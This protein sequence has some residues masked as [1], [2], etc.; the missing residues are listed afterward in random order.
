MRTLF[1]VKIRSLINSIRRSSGRKYPALILF[2]TALLIILG[3]FSV[4]IFGFIYTQKEF[5]EPLRF[6]LSKQL[7]TM[8]F[9]T[10]F[11]MLILSA[12]ISTLNIFFL[13]K[14]LKLLFSSPI[15]ENKIFFWK[16]I[17]VAINS[18]IMVVFFSAPVLFGFLYYF[19]PGILTISMTLISFLLFIL[20]GVGIGI[21]TGFIIPAFISVKRLQPVLSVISILFISLAIIFFRMLQPEKFGNPEILDNVLKFIKGFS[22]PIFNF[23]PFQWLSESMISVSKGDLPRY[24]RLTSYFSLL[25]L[26][27]FIFLRI[28]GKK[29]YFSLYDKINRGSRGSKRSVWNRKS[30]KGDFGTLLKKESRTF[31]RTPEH[32]SQ[33]LVIGAIA[34]IFIINMKAIPAPSAAVKNIIAY[35]NIGMAA[36]IVAGLNSRFTFTSIPMENPGVVY[37]LSSP[38]KREKVLKFKLIVNLIP[39][40]FIS[41]SLFFT[42]EITLKLDIV[43]RV[44]GTLYLIP[45]VTFLTIL[46]LHYGLKIKGKNIISPQHLIISRNGISLMLWSMT[47][48]ILSLI[49][50]I[51]PLFLYYFSKFT[52]REIPWN[53]ITLWIIFFIGINLFLI[54]LFYKKMKKKWIDKEFL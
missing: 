19:S 31:F 38:F 10:M 30:L 48:I 35:L 11:I 49:F 14:D 36:F 33:L 34:V 51:R 7:L 3:I 8:I 6:F 44:T 29:F 5:T 15:P 1:N 9:L 18:S 50:L 53:E 24:L 2:G 4:K 21:I 22:T 23:L 40:L 32:W 25:L 27:L 39:M 41:L 12:M 37:I 16:G 52:K 54:I 28:F 20:I 43:T 26:F 13:S 45:I 46:A 17:E 47:Y 42:G